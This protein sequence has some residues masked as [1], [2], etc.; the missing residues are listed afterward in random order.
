MRQ[1]ALFPYLQEIKMPSSAGSLNTWFRK[2]EQIKWNS[3]TVR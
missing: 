3:L 1:N 2:K